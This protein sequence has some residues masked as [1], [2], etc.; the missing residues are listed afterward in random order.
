MLLLMLLVSCKSSNTTHVT[1]VSRTAEFQHEIDCLIARDAENKRWAR[2]YL[3]EIDQAMRNDD[4][5]AYVFFVA[6]YERVPKEIVPEHLRN[7]P[8][9]VEPP[10]D[11]E[12]HFR[13]RWFEQAILLYKQQKQTLHP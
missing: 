7:E 10:S 12:L 9:Y 13:L 3:Y 1:R 4:V 8:G 6:Q 2:I 11:L 5:A